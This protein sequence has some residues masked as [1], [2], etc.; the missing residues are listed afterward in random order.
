MQAWD[1]GSLSTARRVSVGMAQAAGSAQPAHTGTDPS[2]QAAALA[3][4]AGNASGNSWGL[5]GDVVGGV[6]GQM[7]VGALFMT[8]STR[9]LSGADGGV[10]GASGKRLSATSGLASPRAMPPISTLDNKQLIATLEEWQA[11]GGE[12]GDGGG[13]SEGQGLPSPTAIATL[14]A[15]PPP[16]RS[17]PPPAITHTAS[18]V[19]EFPWLELLKPTRMNKVRLA[20]DKPHTAPHKSK[21]ASSGVEF[22][23]DTF[24]QLHVCN[25]L[26]GVRGVGSDRVQS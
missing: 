23:C 4:N 3:A 14:V 6:S 7:G 20:K 24:F 10:G 12:G 13:T 16:P 25:L 11:A 19:F 15:R 9:S 26:F 21:T 2:Q 22:E 18:H 5:G 8:G 17:G 1:V